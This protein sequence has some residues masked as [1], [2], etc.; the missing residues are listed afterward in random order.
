MSKTVSV[1]F[2]YFKGIEFELRHLRYFVAVAEEKNFTRAAEKLFIAQPPLSR[3]IQQLEEELG[4]K[5]FE[6]GVRPLKTTMAGEFFYEHGKQ[7]LVQVNELK[8]MTQRLGNVNE[9]LRVAYVAS[10]LYGKLP[11]IINIF[12]Q[13]YGNIA[14][15]LFEMTTMEQIHALKEGDIDIG[16][17]RL[18][19]QDPSVRRI[20][21]RKEP[22][23]LAVPF[24]H[25]FIGRK[26][27]TLDQ[28]VSEK[29]II[30]PQ[31]PRPSFADQVLEIFK[32]IGLQPERLFEARELHIAMGLVAAGEGVS[33]V[34]EGLARVNVQDIAF[35]PIVDDH[36]FSPIMMSTRTKDK[37]DNI[38][39]MLNI[40]YDIYDQE[41]IA[42]IR[43]KI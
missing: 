28:I 24:N 27:I 8:L 30:Y 18:Y 9:S 26:E 13:R 25:R 29:I 31:K 5:L 15:E 41:K 16:F 32:F 39:N 3:Q 37:S 19:L 10:T 1:C 2:S 35:I 21:L 11:Q 6:R 20:V 36:A 17:G 7:L 42:Y 43:R 34:P 12:R 38:R 22:L 23:V 4:V 14:L 40:I 33:L